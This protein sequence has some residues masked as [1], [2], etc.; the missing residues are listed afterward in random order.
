MVLLGRRRVL[1]GPTGVLHCR[2]CGSAK[3]LVQGADQEDRKKTLRLKCAE[4]SE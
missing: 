4:C 2:K 3:L 1:V